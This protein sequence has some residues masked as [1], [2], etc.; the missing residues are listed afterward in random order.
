MRL[1]PFHSLLAATWIVSALPSAPE[2][3]PS[4]AR[5]A[6]AFIFELEDGHVRIAA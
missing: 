1:Y 3:Q 6:G 4:R 2:L 5:V